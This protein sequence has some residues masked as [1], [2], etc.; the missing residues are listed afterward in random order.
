MPAVGVLGGLRAAAADFFWLQA[1]ECAEVHDLPATEAL[2][3]VVMV[4]DSRPVYFWVNAARITA[5]DMPVWRIELAGG[6]ER[7]SRAAQEDIN[8]EQAQQAIALLGRARAFHPDSAALWIERA[9]LELNRLHDP[10]AAAESY[11]R[12]WSQPS[13]P[14]YAARLHAE[15][16]RRLGRKSEALAWLVQLHPRLPAQD[17]AAGAELVLARIRDLERELGV[18]EAKRYR[19]G[20]RA[21]L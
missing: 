4:V 10:A 7:V 8:R 13:A 9:N 3:G 17:E 2:L 11:R 20:S 18:P 16:L 1:Q 14:F 19:P 15:L 12:A 5:Y 21:G 6:Y